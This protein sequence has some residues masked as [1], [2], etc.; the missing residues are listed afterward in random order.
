MVEKRKLPGGS[1]SDK[2]IKHTWW[3]KC[4]LPVNLRLSHRR[5]SGS[6]S[7]C[8]WVRVTWQFVPDM[9]V[10]FTFNLN[11]GKS[12]KKKNLAYN[13]WR[14]NRCIISELREPIIT[15]CAVEPQ[16]NWNVSYGDNLGHKCD[17]FSVVGCGQKCLKACA[18]QQ[19]YVIEMAEV[20]F[21]DGIL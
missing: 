10:C 17:R 9:R 20:K 8:V 16:K 4:T 19:P 14:W 7:S 1:F 15:W 12:K 3:P 18:P 13:H 5:D 6:P 21:V 11:G 2:I